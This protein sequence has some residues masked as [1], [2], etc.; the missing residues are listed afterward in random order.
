MIGKQSLFQAFQNAFSGMIHCVIHERNMKIHMMFALIAGGLAWRLQLDR[1]E[2]LILLLTIAS[3]LFAE[4]VN[5]VV[6][7]MVDL[8][9]PQIHP[10]AKIAKDVAAGAVLLTAINSLFVAYI[11]FGEKMT[12]YFFR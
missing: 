12:G 11:L 3:V 8:I 2:T 5:T 1:Y 6:E 9:S 10:L 4:M 7:T